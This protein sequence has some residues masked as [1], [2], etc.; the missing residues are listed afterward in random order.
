YRFTG[1]NVVIFLFAVS[2]FVPPGY[3]I[4]PLFGIAYQ[5]GLLNTLLGVILAEAGSPQLAVFMLLAA[6]YFNR[7]PNEVAEAARIDGC[8][9]LGTF[10]RVMLPLGAPIIVT[11]CIMQTIFTWN[12]F[13]IPLVFTLTASNLRPLGV[14]M[15]AFQGEYTSDWTG[16][17][18]GALIGIVPVVAVF[19]ALQRYF[20]EG[21]AGAI[22][23]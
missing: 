21:V 4:V 13:F 14:G 16:M 12:A 15:F 8:G 6:G 19:L 2:L 9:F 11:I 1:R 23:G 18:A 17:A 20:I 10:W 7:L 3:I 22:K 5:L